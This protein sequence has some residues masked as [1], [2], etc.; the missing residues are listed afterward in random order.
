MQRQRPGFTLVELLV[1]IAIIGILIALLLPAVQAAREAARRSECKN[2][3]KQ[4]G[5]AIH[6]HVDTQNILPTAGWHWS[7]A[8]EYTS[9]GT[10]EAAPH[11]RAGWG[12]Q[13]LPYME[14]GN[15]WKGGGETNNADRQRLVIAAVIDGMYCPSRRKAA[16]LPP[17]NRWYGPSGSY[18]HGTTDY[19][20][21][22]HTTGRIDG[23][24]DNRGVGAIVRHN[25]GG[26]RT[27]TFASLTDGTSQTMLVG[28]KRLNTSS[29]LGTYQGDDNEGYT[30]GWDHDV[31]RYTHR[32]PRPDCQ[33][34]GCWG[35]V[36]F[37]SAHA[38]G[39]QAVFGDGSVHTI[40]YNVNLDI[41]RR[42]G[43]RSDGLDFEF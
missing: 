19:A 18:A 37:G 14:Q 36:R 17:R 7:H 39:F 5:L 31:I 8:P 16:A 12:F 24:S 40:R 2:N 15:L 25:G 23:G 26:D 30:S 10:P 1:V 11:Q 20:A 13:I 22:S 6:N 41:F 3:L 4:I 43:E 21:S 32:Q 38:A 9:D 35:E 29:R 42:M 33:T 34:P 27:L 28:E